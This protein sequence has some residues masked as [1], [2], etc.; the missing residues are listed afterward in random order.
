MQALTNIQYE[1]FMVICVTVDTLMKAK[2]DAVMIDMSGGSLSSCNEHF[3]IHR[4]CS[5]NLDSFLLFHQL[6]DI[7]ILHH[8]V[9][10]HLLRVVFH[11]GAP[12]KCILK[13][14]DEVFVNLQAEILD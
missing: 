14:F 7:F 5:E 11:R 9:L 1:L 13:F 10:A 2:T 3:V 6:D 4:S 8:V 12:H